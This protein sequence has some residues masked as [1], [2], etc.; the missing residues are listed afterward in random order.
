MP[1]PDE[2]APVVVVDHD[3]AWADAFAALAGRLAV[4]LGDLAVGIDHI[5]STS[6]P[7]LPAK[8]CIDAQV[9]VRR[10]EVAAVA[11]R[12]AAPGFRLRP[13]PWN[14]LETS[15]GETSPKL[16]FAPPPGE[17]ACNV[18]I[19]LH[20]GAGARFALLFRDYLSAD[21]PARQAWGAFKR[22]LAQSTPDLLDYG[23]IKAPATDVLM[24]AARRW[25]EQTGWSAPA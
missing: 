2:V 11:G 13:E 24:I 12:L 19:R 14:R 9:R 5:G 3:P 16:V 21:E 25:A 6:V 7:G 23:Q 15:F 1:F 4:A 10:I 8:D 17:R 22:R 20:G 18:H